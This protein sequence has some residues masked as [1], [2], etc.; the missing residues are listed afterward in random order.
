MTL[1]PGIQALLQDSHAGKFEVVL[2]E[3]LDRVLRD[4]ANVATLYEHLQLRGFGSSSSLKAESVN[5]MS[6]S[7]AR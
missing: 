6:A 7:R 3:A 1:R 4:Q 5:S 2:A